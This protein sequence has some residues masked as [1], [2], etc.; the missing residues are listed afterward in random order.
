MIQKMEREGKSPA[1]IKKARWFLELLKGIADRPIA[2]IMPHE[3]LDALKRIERCGHHETAL[4]PRSL[5]GVCF[6]MASRRRH[7]NMALPISFAAR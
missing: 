6:A 7:P 4:R 1:T 2:W 3:L 5:P